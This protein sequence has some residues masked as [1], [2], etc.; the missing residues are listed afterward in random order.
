MGG[1]KVAY[2]W[3]E[4]HLAK[5]EGWLTSC[6]VY[7]RD[8]KKYSCEYAFKLRAATKCFSQY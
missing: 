8:N 1:S 6:K 7:V 4:I 3:S 5:S 2:M